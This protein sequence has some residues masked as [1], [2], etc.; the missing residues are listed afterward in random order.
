MADASGED[1]QERL[2]SALWFAIGKMVDDESL[3]RNMNATP[4]FIGALTELVWT[5]IEN[6]AIDLETFSQHAGRTTVTT[7]DVLLLAR[8]NSDLQSVIKD[9][10]DKLKAAKVKE[11]TRAGKKK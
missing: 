1:V 2:K 8:R 5:Q 9:C 7:D 10:V 6:V 4:Q 3:R 11:K